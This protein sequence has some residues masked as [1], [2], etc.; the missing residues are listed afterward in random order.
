MHG[1]LKIE[2]IYVYMGGEG[3]VERDGTLKSSYT[4]SQ[5]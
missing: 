1:A 3:G 4:Y 2:V 5:S